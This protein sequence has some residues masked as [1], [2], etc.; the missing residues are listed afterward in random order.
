MDLRV[1]EYRLVKKIGAGSFS[2]VYLGVHLIT[3]EEVA[4]KLEPCR[5]K[6]YQI[7]HEA[8]VYK[9]LADG[10]ECK[11]SAMVI[12]LLGPS[13]EDLFNF[14]KHKFSLKTTLLLADQLLYRLKYVHLHNFIHRDIK[15]DNFLMGISK[16]ANQGVEQSCRD[17]MESLA[18]MLICFLRGSLPWQGIRGATK[19][20][21]YDRIMEK[22]MT[23]PIEFLGRGLL[24]EFVIFLKYTRCLRFDDKPDYNYLCS[25]F[26]SSFVQ[27]GYSYD[28]V[29][30]WS[31]KTPNGDASCVP[32]REQIAAQEPTVP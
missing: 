27:E 32:T 6:H 4:V 11:Y 23:T 7:D 21:K 29:F 19:I 18:Y 12:E 16:R 10:V 31:L 17:D 1:C 8:H 20:Q 3:D 30:D 13:L 24:Q 26:R 28:Y 14:C 15:P 5:E 22:K 9:L 25:L 2:E